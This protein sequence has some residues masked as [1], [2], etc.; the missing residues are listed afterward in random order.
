MHAARAALASMSPRRA[1]R[2]AQEG[3]RL[4]ERD[5]VLR[6]AATRGEVRVVYQPIFELRTGRLCGTEALMRW[7]V[8]GEVRL[9]AAFI[10]D[11]EQTGAIVPMTS[12]V[13]AEAAA[14]AA[15]WRAAMTSTDGFTMSVNLSAR[16]LVEDDLVAEVRATLATAGLDAA[17]L[18]LEVTETAV[19]SDMDRAIAQLQAVRDLGVSIAVDDFGTGQSS[20]SYLHR[21]PV[22]VIKL[23]RQFVATITEPR[24]EAVASAVVALASSLGAAT[25]AEGIEDEGQADRLRALGCDRGQGFYYARPG[26]PQAIDRILSMAGPVRPIPQP[27]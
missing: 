12:A 11:A 18:Q 10:D 16:H 19:I 14:Q 27:D 5:R 2:A 1:L 21:F 26:P 8:D 22:D 24:G 25:V 23:D 7:V 13:L 3:Y 15:R 17:D 4:A 20:L 9:P 6:A